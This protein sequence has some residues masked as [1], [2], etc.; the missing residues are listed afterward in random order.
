MTCKAER[1]P[2]RGLPPSQGLNSDQIVNKGRAITERTCSRRC[3]KIICVE[4]K[5][6]ALPNK[7]PIFN[8]PAS[9]VWSLGLIV[10]V[11][12]YRQWLGPE[13]DFNFVISL[14]FIPARY[15]GAISDIPGGDASAYYSFL[16]YMFVH[17]DWT[18]LVINSLWLLAFG[19]AV[20]RR[21]GDINYVLFSILCGLGGILTHLF[22]HWGDISPVVGASAAISGQMAGAI[23]F[24]FGAYKY[25]QLA[26]SRIDPKGT[27]LVGVVEALKDPKIVVFLLIWLGL[28]ILVGVGG[29]SIGQSAS[30]A[31]EAHIGGFITGLLLFGIMDRMHS[32]AV[33]IPPENWE[34]D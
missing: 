14:A 31:W 32:A 2:A 11:Q 17:G 15:A 8:I 22:I 3:K 13:A 34:E 19:S 23:R 1:V 4:N 12:L 16:T 25:G 26:E 6:Y 27:R 7:A 21:I 24:I 18:H 28:N 20:A 9:V 29:V 5:D 30:V 10:A 33:S